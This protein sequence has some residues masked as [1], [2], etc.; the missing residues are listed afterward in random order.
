MKF[1]I[2]KNSKDSIAK[3]IT[4]LQN[5]KEKDFN[6]TIQLNDY[7]WDKE[8]VEAIEKL[9]RNKAVN[10]VV[11]TS[12]YK[13]LNG[14]FATKLFQLKLNNGSSFKVLDKVQKLHADL[15]EEWLK[16]ESQFV[17]DLEILAQKQKIDDKIFTKLCNFIATAPCLEKLVIN[18]FVS[19]E[20]DKKVME[21]LDKRKASKLPEIKFYFDESTNIKKESE[22]A[23]TQLNQKRMMLLGFAAIGCVFGGA[24][25]AASSSPFAFLLL[26]ATVV[27]LVAGKYA[28]GKCATSVKPEASGI[29]AS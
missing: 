2:K 12:N 20:D 15:T 17:Y 22:N 1:K 5:N 27:V 14:D 3:Q 10:L 21:A 4:D 7:N 6:L 8:E 24:A 9:L 29:S 13:A 16:K 25:Y 23:R 18:D 11:K 19:A 26:P 28:I